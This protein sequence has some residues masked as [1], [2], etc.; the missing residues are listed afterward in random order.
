M[1]TK[2]LSFLLILIVPLLLFAG[3]N[4]KPE[5]QINMS[6]YFTTCSYTLKDSSGSVTGDINNHLSN[7]HS[8]M[9][10]Y[11]TLTIRGDSNWLYGMTLEYINFELYSAASGEFEI[12]MRIT[13]LTKGTNEQEQDPEKMLIE[14]YS[15]SITANTTKSI[16]ID[17]NDIV[18]SIT[19][20]TNITFT[21]IEAPTTTYTIESIQLFGQHK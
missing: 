17:I 1:K 16:K 2:L 11:E 20:D 4:K 6:R 21:F 14:T 18:K 8:A 13:N 5:N 15:S 3:C 9:K 12:E 7:K 10:Q 19:A